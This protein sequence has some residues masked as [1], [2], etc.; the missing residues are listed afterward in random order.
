MPQLT[1]TKERAKKIVMGWDDGFEK[2]KSTYREI[3]SGVDSVTAIVKDLETGKHYRSTY[4]HGCKT[5]SRTEYMPYDTDDP[6]FIEVEPR[7]IAV[8]KVEWDEV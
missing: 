6:V 4:T 7:E 5:Y 3:S 1:F 8:K 2:V